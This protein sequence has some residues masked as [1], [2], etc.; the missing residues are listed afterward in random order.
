MPTVEELH[1]GAALAME[2][3]ADLAGVTPV[4]RNP[5]CFESA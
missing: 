2:G 5:R 4:R 3:A 1:D